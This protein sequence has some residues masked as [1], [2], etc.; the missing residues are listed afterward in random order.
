M[1][2]SCNYYFRCSIY[3]SVFCRLQNKRKLAI[4]SN[5]IKSNIFLCTKKKINAVAT[6]IIF[7]NY[8]IYID[9]YI[10]IYIIYI[11]IYIIY[12]YYI[13]IYILL[14]YIII[15]YSYI[16][17]NII[18]NDVLVQK[19][20]GEAILVKFLNPFEDEQNLFMGASKQVQCKKR[21]MQQ[22]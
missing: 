3:A 22:I 7:Y 14:L 10:Y 18:I 19:G 2:F 16:N 6:S 12:I 5:Q 20:S 17:Y 9:I 8:I 21:S 13:D 15:Y 1:H 11:Y 4:K